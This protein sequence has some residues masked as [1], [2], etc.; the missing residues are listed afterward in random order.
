VSP[1]K[2]PGHQTLYSHPQTPNPSAD[3]RL[4]EPSLPSSLSA[5]ITAEL[6]T[7]SVEITARSAPS[8]GRLTPHSL[9]LGPKIP[10]A[11][12]DASRRRPNP[13]PPL[14]TSLNTSSAKSAQPGGRTRVAAE[15]AALATCPGQLTIPSSGTPLRRLADACQDSVPQKVTPIQRTGATGTTQELAMAPAIAS[16]AGPQMTHLERRPLNR[17]AG[18]SHL[19]R[20]SCAPSAALA[21]PC[22]TASAVLT[23]TPACRTGSS[24]DPTTASAAARLQR[25]VRLSG[26]TSNAPLPERAYAAATAATA[27]SPGKPPTLP[28]LKA[29]PSTADAGTGGAAEPIPLLI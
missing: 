21:A 7:A 29:T 13:L 23:A 25:S 24:T 3:V 28:L 1:A 17:C 20:L 8:P 19:K 11:T 6:M 4:T 14:S 26:A 5:L 10:S 16:R 12:A 9:I 27:A 15:M 22:T 18:A 2:C